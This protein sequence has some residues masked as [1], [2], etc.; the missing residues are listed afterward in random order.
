MMQ[1][2]NAMQNLDCENALKEKYK[3]NE[4]LNS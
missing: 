1:Y 3:I 2:T 4:K